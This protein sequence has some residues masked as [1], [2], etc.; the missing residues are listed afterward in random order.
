M[1]ACPVVPRFPFATYELKTIHENPTARVL[2]GEAASFIPF[3]KKLSVPPLDLRTIRLYRVVAATVVPADTKADPSYHPQLLL[4]LACLIA[5]EPIP[6][7]KRYSNEPA[8]AP[9]VIH[10]NNVKSVEDGTVLSTL[11]CKSELALAKYI[12]LLPP[13]LL[14]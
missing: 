9:V 5:I 13:A 6:I 11:N 12:D 4:M 3:L 10:I 7:E 1:C 8:S 14:G 2:V